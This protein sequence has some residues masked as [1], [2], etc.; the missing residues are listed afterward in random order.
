LRDITEHSS[1]GT[2]YR[3]KK[4]EGGKNEER[5]ERKEKLA[6]EDELTAC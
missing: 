2:E 4:E 1:K 6:L 5:I 3:K